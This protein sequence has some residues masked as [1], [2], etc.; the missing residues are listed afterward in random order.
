MRTIW[1]PDFSYNNLNYLNYFVDIIS[2]ESVQ[3]SRAGNIIN[4]ELYL[5]QSEMKKIVENAIEDPTY[6]ERLAPT[7]S[8]IDLSTCFTSPSTPLFPIISSPITGLP[9]LPSEKS[10]TKLTH[11]TFLDLD[12]EDFAMVLAA[13]EKENIDRLTVKGFVLH[14]WESHKESN[15]IEQIAPINNLVDKFNRICFWVATEICTQPGT[16]CMT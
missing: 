5:L 15:I 3:N 11:L 16:I 8:T 14:L 10:A 9:P 1:Q 7:A 6:L 12:A 13:E 2:D 4:Q